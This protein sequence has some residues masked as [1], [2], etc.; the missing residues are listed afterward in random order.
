MNVEQFPAP[1]RPVL[2]LFHVDFRSNG[3]PRG[4]AW[5]LATVVA[6]AGSLAIDAV[7]VTIGQRVFPSTTGYAHFQF[8]DYS[9]LTVIGVLI[10]AVAWPVTTAITSTPRWL[11]TRMAWIVTIVL[12]APD[13]YIWHGGQP[14][15]AVFVLMWM[16]VG[17]AIV[18][19]AALTRLA[20]SR[21]QFRGRHRRFG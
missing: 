8:S 12:F 10:A 3:Q 15:K 4:G 9:K 16:H 2:R 11:F 20:P 18:T 13:L 17:I 21:R 19:Y 14:F 6:L 7:L 5:L 1:L